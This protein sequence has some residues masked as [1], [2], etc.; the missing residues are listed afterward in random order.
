MMELSE[1]VTGM[2]SEDYKERFKAEYQQTKIRYEKLKD[3]CNLIEVGE[4]METI[5]EPEHQTPLY[6]LRDQQNVIG[7][8]LNIL[9]KRAI[10]EGITLEF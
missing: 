9:E 2:T 4:M 10:I 8:Y 3:F 7:N 5:D 6:M 1:T